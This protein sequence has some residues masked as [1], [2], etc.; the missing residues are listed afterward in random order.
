MIRPFTCLAFLLACGSGLYLYQS[1]HRVKVLDEQIAQVAHATDALREQTRMLS[2]EWTLLNDPERLRQLAN[3]FLSL[4]TVSPNQFTSLAD[5]DTRLPPVPPPAPPPP[6]TDTSPSDQGTVP[7]ASDD[8]NGGGRDEGKPAA[9]DAR[10]APA[11]VKTAAASPKAPTASAAT[12][13]A[14]ASPADASH[15][16]EHK[17]A[18]VRVASAP[19][20][21][22]TEPSHPAEQLEPWEWTPDPPRA[23]QSHPEQPRADQSRALQP[24]LVQV[25]VQPRLAQA[26]VHAMSTAPRLPARYPAAPVGSQSNGS[27]L[28][29][30]PGMGAP[31]A[32]TPL[33]RP[34]PVSA[35]PWSYSTG[36]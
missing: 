2:A 14:T 5:L 6:T 19:P 7:V 24:R 18:P 13:V 16:V 29:M 36:G 21:P 1:K 26:Q 12:R 33:P 8:A 9:A 28:G 20:R 32:P 23:V 30:A 25:A 4:Q 17:P 35:P 27:L 3:Q 15:A 22:A 31:P 10:P 11:D 34:T